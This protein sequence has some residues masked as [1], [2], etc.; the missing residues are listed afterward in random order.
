MAEEEEPKD[1]RLKPAGEAKV[2]QKP[3]AEAP[4]PGKAI[5]PRRP[6]PPVPDKK[7]DEEEKKGE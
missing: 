1:V 2:E 6:I 5:H 7:E 4:P 3:C